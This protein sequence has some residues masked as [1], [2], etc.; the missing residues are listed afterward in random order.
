MKSSLQ[1]APLFHALPGRI[2]ARA[3][4][5]VPSRPGARCGPAAW[6]L[7]WVCLAG[8]APGLGA[9]DLLV[10]EYFNYQGRLESTDQSK[11]YIDGSYTIDFR[12][13][14]SPS[15]PG[16]L[17]WAESYS[18]Y[19]KG[20]N[21]NVVLGEGGNALLSSP[22]PACNYLRDVFRTAAT[23][24]DRYL[25]I[26]VRQDESHNLINSAVECSPRQQML[27]APFAFQAQYAQSANAAGTAQFVATN[28]LRVS[29]RVFIAEMGAQCNQGL[30]VA[31]AKAVVKNGLDV[32]GNT[33]SDGLV[34]NGATTL[35]GNLTFQDCNTTNGG[36]VPVRGII[37]WSGTVPPPGWAL[38]DGTTNNGQICPDLRG[39]FVLG[40]GQGPGLASRVLGASGGEESHLI[41]ITEL[42]SHTH[43][44]NVTAVGYDSGWNESAEVVRAP[45]EI[46][47]DNGAQSFTTTLAG[48]NTPMPLL[49]PFYALAYIMRVQ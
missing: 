25:G 38:C 45:T 19:V 44:L 29:G 39:R 23:K 12:I 6:L 18:V 31:G 21:F 49:P 28:G 34:V 17:L 35:K 14:D 22:P 2:A 27:S 26:T 20:G 7:G 37:M 9:Q 48:S 47:K 16:G 42:P 30:T 10:P 40:T 13:W 15:N 32:S 46:R 33:T 41:S 11:S 5:P 1:A 3:A 43:G 4:S 24:T 36:V 8:L